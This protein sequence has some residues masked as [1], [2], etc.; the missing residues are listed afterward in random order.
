[1]GQTREALDA[2][3]QAARY[4]PEKIDSY[5]WLADLHLQ[6]GE[7]DDARRWTELAG[8]INPD[9]RRLAGLKE[10]LGR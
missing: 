6:R 2:F 9:D 8:H 1:M 4:N 7:L 10:K 3:R 5:L